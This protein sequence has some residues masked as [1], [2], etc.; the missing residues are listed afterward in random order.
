MISNFE[1]TMIDGI[2]GI[3]RCQR[4]ASPI[5]ATGSVDQALA[6]AAVAT[7]RFRAFSLV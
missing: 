2:T 7:G 3:C 1:L 6:T 4:L 5:S